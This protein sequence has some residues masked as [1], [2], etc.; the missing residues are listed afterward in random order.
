MIA[1]L[2]GAVLM[3]GLAT[4]GPSAR[5]ATFS[6]RVEGV[7][8]DVL[9]TDGGRPVPGL[10]PADFEVRDNG[11][12]QTIDLVSLGD[13]PLGVMLALDASRSVNGEQLRNLRAAG[14][15]LLDGLRADD[16]ASLLTFDLAVALRAPFT[17]AFA[18]VARALDE[19]T[20]SGDT[21]LVDAALGAVL[22]ADR[23]GGR[24]VVVI[25]SDGTDTA[26][27]MPAD[28]VVQTAERS[29]VLVYGV[30]APG[31]DDTGFLRALAAGTGGRLVELERAGD[32]GAAFR[33]ILEEVR[34][35]YLVTFTPT[36]VA[37]GG[38]HRLDV[39]VNRRGARVHA[40]S[41]YVSASQ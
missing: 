35:R 26:S 38:W 16:R 5:Q 31:V 6:A 3:A 17:S 20:A 29:R 19:T 30:A 11:V 36:G 14:R 41:G 9:V 37:R 40:R 33:D 27:F 7:R 18:D 34:R 12:L 32:P 2:A 4:A 28:R 24:N 25:F 39:R 15:L 13:V 10:G 23:D 8:I 21:A 22:V 1:R